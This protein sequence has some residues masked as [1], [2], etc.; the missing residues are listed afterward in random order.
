MVNRLISDGGHPAE[1]RREE[2]RLLQRLDDHLPRTHARPAQLAAGD[3]PVVAPVRSLLTPRRHPGPSRRAAIERE[4][5]STRR[6]VLTL[7]D[8]ECAGKRII[9][10]QGAV[11]AAVAERLRR[12]APVSG[13]LGPRVA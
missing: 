13:Y 12:K 11:I 6:V 10:T 5:G 1:R 7:P 2:E 3:I 4:I 8:D 9:Q